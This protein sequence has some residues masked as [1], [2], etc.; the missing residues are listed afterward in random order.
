MNAKQIEKLLKTMSK[1]DLIQLSKYFSVPITRQIGGYYNKN[2]MLQNLMY[3]QMGGADSGPGSGPASGTESDPYHLEL[4][5]NIFDVY[6]K[7]NISNRHTGVTEVNSELLE[8]LFN[9]AVPDP[10]PFRDLNGN[11]DAGHWGLCELELPEIVKETK[12]YKELNKT[13]PPLSELHK[14]L[15]QK[16]EDSKSA[17]ESIF[18][19]EI[20]SNETWD[21]Q[22]LLNGITLR[23]I[24]K[25]DGHHHGPETKDHGPEKFLNN[26]SGINLGRYLKDR[27]LI[28]ILVHRKPTERKFEINKNPFLSDIHDTKHTKFE[29]STRYIEDVLLAGSKNKVGIRDSLLTSPKTGGITHNTKVQSDDPK[30]K[31]KKKKK[32]I[33]DDDS[34]KWIKD[35][36]SWNKASVFVTK[37]DR[38][39]HRF[40]YRIDLTVH[41]TTLLS[42]AFKTQEDM[43]EFLTYV[44][45]VNWGYT[46]HTVTPT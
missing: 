19:E 26:I 21:V 33:K 41:G 18:Q 42:I 20:K 10:R 37:G 27:K 24:K 43:L 9:I 23:I 1:K 39:Y 5:K 6:I 16:K 32:R 12:K 30:I 46:D 40:M 2:Q 28:P 13:P 38:G 44:N 14:Y 11:I 15:Q 25:K 34:E 17:S 29:I 36:D 35:D 3:R 7:F 22:L 4:S 8:K 45:Y 31:K